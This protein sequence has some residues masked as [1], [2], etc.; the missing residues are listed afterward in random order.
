MAKL[1]APASS[2]TRGD[3]LK[4]RR[5]VM[6]ASW[7]GNVY[8]RKWPR[9]R[10]KKK[11]PLQ[12]AWVDRFSYLARA[13]K[14]PLPQSLDAAQMWAKGTGWYYRDVLEVAAA[15]KLIRFNGEPRVTTPTARVYRNA[16][17]AVTNGA[18]GYL[19]PDAMNWDNNVFWS[20]TVNPSRL[21][22]KAPG[23]YLVGG[24]TYF[25]AITGGRR[26]MGLVVNRTT[27]IVEDFRT[28][29]SATALTIPVVSLWYFHAND[30]LE[31]WQFVNANG[32]TAR[33][34]SL[35]AVAITPEGIVP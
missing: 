2:I 26:D 32:V 12:Q 4:V 8:L 35:W 21:T 6:L 10:G 30:Y 17:Q 33:L 7:K 22:F 1:D 9:P 16:A 11:T 14:S 5:R 19:T 13:L 24:H 27:W 23:L 25:N 29:A 3:V 34:G 18:G 31:A 15:G 28:P 20:P